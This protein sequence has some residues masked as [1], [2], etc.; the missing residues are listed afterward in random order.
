MLSEPAPFLRNPLIQTP[1]ETTHKIHDHNYY[2]PYHIP[3]KKHTVSYFTSLT[4]ISEPPHLLN[5]RGVGVPWF[6]D[7]DDDVDD[8]DGAIAAKLHEDVVTFTLSCQTQ[9][10]SSSRAGWGDSEG[11]HTPLLGG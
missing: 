6:Y 2:P 3:H 5:T 9:A 7:D 4:L 1:S 10:P 11:R 8:D